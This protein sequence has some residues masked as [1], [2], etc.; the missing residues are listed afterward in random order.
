M[1]FTANL[2]TN[3]YTHVMFVPEGTAFTVPGAGTASKTSKP[4]SGDTSWTTGNLGD[5]EEFKLA[6]ESESY[7]IMGG[8][9]G[10]LALKNRVELSKRLKVTFTATRRDPITAQ[11]TF[12][13][14]TLTAASTQGNPL[15][16]KLNIKGWLKFQ[17]YDGDGTL[18]ET[19]DLWVTLKLTS[20]EPRSGRN[21]VKASYECEVEYSTLNTIA[22]A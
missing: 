15:E 12:G 18:R 19:G 4:G 14:L 17:S 10:G 16:G 9:P 5:C 8:T 3:F 11:A 2:E 7:D 6:P 13:T 22:F 1:A 21:P 20:V